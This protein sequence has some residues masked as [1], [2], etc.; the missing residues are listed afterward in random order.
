MDNEKQIKAA[1]KEAHTIL[2]DLK[3]WDDIIPFNI[4]TDLDALTKD[5]TKQ[6]KIIEL[7]LE[8]R[9]NNGKL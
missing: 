1:I 2:K 8:R 3:Y 7:E 4:K 5:I 6:L 9:L